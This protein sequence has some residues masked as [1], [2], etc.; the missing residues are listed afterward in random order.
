MRSK[1][2]KKNAKER[3]LPSWRDVVVWSDFRQLH[4]SKAIWANYIQQMMSEHFV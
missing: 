2:V 3:G 1:N 4:V